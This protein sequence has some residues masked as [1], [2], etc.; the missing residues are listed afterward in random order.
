MLLMKC[1]VVTNMQK[2]QVSALFFSERSKS[3][4]SNILSKSWS[5]HGEAVGSIRILA[6]NADRLEWLFISQ[7][8]F[9][10]P[11]NFYLKT[12]LWHERNVNVVQAEHHGSTHW[13]T[14]TTLLL[15]E[16]H[17]KLVVCFQSESFQFL[18]SSSL[19]WFVR[20]NP[21]YCCTY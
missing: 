14:S 8:S 20:R 6:T 3:I 21:L 7:I 15:N 9:R 5:R 4:F 13:I 19:K 11:A 16:P 17:S 1:N 12:Q 2:K 18:Y 10:Q